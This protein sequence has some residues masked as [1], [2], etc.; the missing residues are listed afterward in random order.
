MSNTENPSNAGSNPAKR[1]IFPQENE[2]TGVSDTVS[3]RETPESEVKTLRFPK[4][5]KFRGRELATIYGKYKA[6]PQYRVAWSVQGKRRMKAFDRYGGEDGA[7]AY[8]EKLVPDLAKGSQVTALTAG[9]A[10]DAIAALE[11][12][13][14]LWRRSGKRVSLLAAVTE[15]AEA[16]EKL[17]GLTLG[18]ALERYLAT[19][20]TVRRTDLA[21]AV[22]EFIRADE[23]RTKSTNGERAQ[24]SSKY[25]YNRAIVLRRFAG[26]IKNTAVS[27][28]TKSLLDEFFKSLADFS[29]KSRNHHR[30]AIRQFLQWSVRKDYLSV[31]H[32]LGEADS[33]RPELANHGEIEFYTSKEFRAL[34][35]TAQGPMQAMIALGG[36]AGL[37][38]AELLRLTWEDVWR[39]PG[40]VEVTAGKAKTRQRRLVELCSSLAAWLE[41]FRSC[42]TGKVCPITAASAEILWQQEFVE[43][44]NLA[45]VTRKANGLRHAF[46]T[47]HFAAHAN[48][49]LTAAMAGNSPSMI[50]SNYKGLATKA[51]AEKWFGVSPA[52]ADN[53]LPMTAA[54]ESK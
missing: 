19:V 47:Y 31:A 5:I 42:K 32:R 3:T 34:L 28:L 24:L 23:P 16:A 9:Q 2:Q 49:N 33:L 7:L 54:D 10:T 53:V 11:R 14:T 43:L 50:H 52:K 30:G 17:N 15:F 45:K 18:E 29:P 13:E 21:E 4:R 51:E 26:A 37:R 1:T 25:A 27:E 39:V 38:T 20:A 44:C 12:L 22:E 36:L 41:P 40:H 6:Y 46:C 8:A 48:E 35:E